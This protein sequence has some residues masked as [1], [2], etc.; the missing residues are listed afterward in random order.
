MKGFNLLSRISDE[1]VMCTLC[2]H[3]IPLTEDHD[4]V[5]CDSCGEL[6]HDEQHLLAQ[7]WEYT[8]KAYQPQG[9]IHLTYDENIEI[10]KHLLL[11]Y[12]NMQRLCEVLC[13][14]YAQMDEITPKKLL[15]IPEEF[16]DID[17]MECTC[18]SIVDYVSDVLKSKRKKRFR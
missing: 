15:D 1:E 11:R 13:K 10:I 17:S 18:D 8:E 5:R 12:V 9:D 3:I 6:L 16:D 2:G 7:L 14:F 4:F